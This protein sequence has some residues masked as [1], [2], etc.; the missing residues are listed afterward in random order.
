MAAGEGAVDFLSHLEH[1]RDQRSNLVDNIEQYKL[2]HLVVIECLFGMRTA[3]ACNDE[4]PG[5]I[6]RTLKNNGIQ[7]ELNHIEETE[8]QDKAMET[9]LEIEETQ[10][11]CPEKNRFAGIEPGKMFHFS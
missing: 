2:A 11:V 5:I 3:I 1:L 8:W 4:L 10:I 9:I 6:E 7:A